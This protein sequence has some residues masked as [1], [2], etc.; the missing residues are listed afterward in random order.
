MVMVTNDK[1]QS[2]HIQDD[3]LTTTGYVVCS[4]HGHIN[5]FKVSSSTVYRGV[6]SLA[7]VF[8]TPLSINNCF[9]C[10]CRCSH[11]SDDN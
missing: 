3:M 1:Y 4:T 2:Q 10:T 6:G 11:G 8:N 7:H 9:M 5:G